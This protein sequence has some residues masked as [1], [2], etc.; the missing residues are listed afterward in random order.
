M[1]K[2]ILTALATAGLLAAGLAQAAGSQYAYGEVLSVTPQYRTVEVSN[3]RQECWDQPV[4]RTTQ[5]QR[6]TAAVIAGGVA[7]GVVGSRFGGGRGRDAAI[8]AGTLAGA[9]IADGLSGTESRTYTVNERQCRTVH[10]TRTEERR[11]GYRVRYLYD[12]QEYSTRT[13]SHPGDRI[14]LRVSVTPDHY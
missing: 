7:G 10:D 13:N 2:P 9:G 11:D 14:R 5:G 3:P 12:G 8:A 6:N 4:Q 1:N